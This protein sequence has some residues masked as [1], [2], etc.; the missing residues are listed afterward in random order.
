MFWN[1]VL[2][3]DMH[4]K[5]ACQLGGSYRVSGRDEDALF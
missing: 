4:D 2:G 1:S 5:Q 3:K